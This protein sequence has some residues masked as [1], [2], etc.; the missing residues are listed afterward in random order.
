MTGLEV[1]LIA[2]AIMLGWGAVAFF[3][4]MGVDHFGNTLRDRWKKKNKQITT[5]QQEIDGHK[6][7]LRVESS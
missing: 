5:S 1:I 7:E 3:F 2:P 6:V 4:G